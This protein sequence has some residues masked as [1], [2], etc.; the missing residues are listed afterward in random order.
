[1]QELGCEEMGR[2]NYLIRKEKD[3]LTVG[4]A[5]TEDSLVFELVSPC[6]ERTA[7]RIAVWV[8]AILRLKG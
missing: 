6:Q 4:P 1:M 7:E 8:D 2:W 3:G 5:E